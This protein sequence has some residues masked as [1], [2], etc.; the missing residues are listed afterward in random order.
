MRSRAV[1]ARAK[2]R[3]A[4]KYARLREKIR[5]GRCAPA[6]TFSRK[7]EE[8]LALYDAG[9]LPD[10]ANLLTRQSGHA[11]LCRSDG[12]F[13]DIGGSTGGF[14]RK[15]LYEWKPPDLQDFD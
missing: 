9:T 6:T 12:S 14:T 13:V 3:L 4:R 15:V 2:L 11:R 5:S 1:E 10:Q 8:L 7:Q